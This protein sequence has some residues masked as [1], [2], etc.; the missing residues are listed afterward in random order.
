MGCVRRGAYY[1]YVY[2]FTLHSS[3]DT[4]MRF[5]YDKMRKMGKS[6]SFGLSTAS[7]SLFIFL[8]FSFRLRRYFK[9]YHSVSQ[10]FVTSHLAFHSIAAYCYCWAFLTLERVAGFVFLSFFFLFRRSP[11]FLFN[12]F[13]MRKYSIEFAAKCE[14]VQNMCCVIFIVLRV[15]GNGKRCMWDVGRVTEPRWRCWN[16]RAHFRF[17]YFILMAG[18]KTAFDVKS[19]A[20]ATTRQA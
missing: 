4:K 15:V 5:I 9:R 17:T 8:C 13:S 12:K 1:K 11:L 6:T 18:T 16:S 20:D 19:K 3:A 2:S 10:S 14:T 7:F